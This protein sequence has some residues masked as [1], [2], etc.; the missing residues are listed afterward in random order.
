MR[1]SIKT[2]QI[3]I[4]TLFFVSF[5]IDSNG[6]T[7]PSDVLQDGTLVEQ[8]DYVQNRTIIYDN[9]RAIREDMFQTIK[10]NSLDSLE[11]AKSNLEGMS[12]QI[13]S[14]E[15]EIDSL[16]TLLTNTRNELNQA[17]ENRDNIVFL[18]IA[19]NKM[20]YNLFV[21]VAIGSLSILLIL[22]FLLYNRNRNVTVQALNEV[23]DLK[24]DYEEYKIASREKREKLVMD[25]FNEIKKLKESEA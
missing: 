4:I 2:F 14:R 9:F 25:H 7:A 1:T 20:S 11:N 8:L 6:Q 21:W 15:R 22:G 5:I 3:L 17:V 18:G 12:A 10:R 23:E 16:T 13:N 24:R 19:M